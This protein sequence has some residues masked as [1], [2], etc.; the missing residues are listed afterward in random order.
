M[1]VCNE[2]NNFVTCRLSSNL[3]TYLGHMTRSRT[4][5]VD[6]MKHNVLLAPH[7]N[8]MYYMF[9]PICLS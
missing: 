4:C 8:I 2:N 9:K 1:Y 5:A 7:I 3:F 6:T